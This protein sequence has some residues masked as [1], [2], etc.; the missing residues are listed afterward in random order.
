MTYE[1]MEKTDRYV[2]L[3][4]GIIS[5]V[6]GLLLFTQTA[7]TLSV[8]MLLVGI[9]WFIQGIVTLLAIFIDKRSWG[10]NLFGGVIGIAAGLIVLQNPLVS[11]VAVP[12][13]LAIMLG[14]F[15]LMIGISALVAAFQGEGWGAGIFGAVSLVIGLLLMFNSIVGGQALVWV[16]ALLLVIQGGI[17]IFFALTNR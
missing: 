12:A 2:L 14:V 3:F 11:T 6:F 16:T 13:V 8:I 15:G 1:K 5:L 17:G 4:G 7:A 10:W 9:T